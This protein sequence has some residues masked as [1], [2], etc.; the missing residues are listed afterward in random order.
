M[1]SSM[2]SLKRKNTWM[3]VVAFDACSGDAEAGESL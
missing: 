3:S 1:S 2:P